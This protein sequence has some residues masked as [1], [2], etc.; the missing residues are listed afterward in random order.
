MLGV[1]L[2]RLRV[3]GTPK[4]TLMAVRSPRLSSECWRYVTPQLPDLVQSIFSVLK[5]GLF[6]KAIW[7]KWSLKELYFGKVWFGNAIT[8]FLL[9]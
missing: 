9:R 6:E 8:E 5:M 7:K 4:F 1:S 2:S 3:M